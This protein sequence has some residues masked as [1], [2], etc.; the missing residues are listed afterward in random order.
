MP[1]R[2]PLPQTLLTELVERFGYAQ[3][4][5]IGDQHGLT[6]IQIYLYEPGG[7]PAEATAAEIRRQLLA[8]AGDVMAAL[9]GGGY[10]VFDSYLT[11]SKLPIVCD[12][13]VTITG[14]L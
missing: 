1:L 14:N 9:D 13:H 4:T 2:A 7:A 8:K 3:V 6:T 5:A 11:L 12:L 10:E